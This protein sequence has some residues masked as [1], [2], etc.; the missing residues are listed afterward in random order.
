LIGG[1]MKTHEKY[2]N[3]YTQNWG[4]IRS[5]VND[6]IKTHKKGKSVPV[7]YYLILDICGEH[8]IYKDDLPDIQGELEDAGYEIDYDRWKK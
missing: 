1:F 5:C 4:K 8:G 7:P 6:I 2:L 3:E